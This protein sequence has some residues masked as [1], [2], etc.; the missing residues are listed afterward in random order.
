MRLLGLTALVGLLVTGA[1][2]ADQSLANMILAIVNDAV[3]TRNEVIIN[4]RSALESVQRAYL[5]RPNLLEREAKKIME[6]SLETLVEQQLIL[7]DYKTSG[8]QFPEAVIEDEIKRRIR[9]RYGDRA[10]LTKELQTQGMTYEDFRQRLREEFIS[11]AMRQRNVSTAL[12]VS[13]AKIERYYQDHATNYAVGDQIK[14][15]AIVRSVPTP[16][17]SAEVRKLML[18]IEHKID[19]STPFSEM[20]TVYSEGSQG[21]L[22]GDWGWQERTYWMKGLADVAAQLEPKQRSRLIGIQRESDSA[23]T[24][25]FYD[26]TGQLQKLRRYGRNAASGKDELRQET[27]VDPQAVARLPEPEE[28]YLIL[29]EDKRAA[30]TKALAEVQD[31]IEKELL[32][33]EAQRLR[34]KWI[35]RLKAKSYVRYF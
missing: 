13:P 6:E 10:N 11:M 30:R 26:A 23:Y 1:A 8:L 24:M 7:N 29:V 27:A 15:R 35:D 3:I 20:A 4:A 18:E 16:D 2:W 21:Q 33:N 12:I 17:A 28:Y 25:F 31:E 9:E 19:R 5:N 34:K 14:I 22:G 32:R